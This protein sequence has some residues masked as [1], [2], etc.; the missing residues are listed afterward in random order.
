MPS[1]QNKY[2]MGLF[3]STGVQ[4]SIFVH[5][6]VEK[7]ATFEI[8]I[9]SNKTTLLIPGLHASVHLVNIVWLQ[10][11]ID[12]AHTIPL[13]GLILRQKAIVSANI[14]YTIKTILMENLVNPT[15]SFKYSYTKS[16][17]FVDSSI[18]RIFPS[19]RFSFIHILFS[20]FLLLK[21]STFN[22]MGSIDERIYMYIT[23]IF[24]ALLP[25][26]EPT[27]YGSPTDDGI[28]K[29]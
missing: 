2:S 1:S 12:W 3:T 8:K 15:K 6:I 4:N 27:H 11:Q 9:K 29:F 14:K 5:W 7:R 19:F 10:M 17:N 28:L 22:S 26:A 24:N 20:F 13:N 25:T 23:W 21:D 16:L 18:Q